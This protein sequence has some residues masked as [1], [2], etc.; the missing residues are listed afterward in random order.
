MFSLRAYS[1]DINIHIEFEYLNCQQLG[2][3]TLVN[4]QRLALLDVE[5][6]DVPPLI[7]DQILNLTNIYQKW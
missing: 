7:I 3:N 5:S 6:N 1:L 4:K 2:P